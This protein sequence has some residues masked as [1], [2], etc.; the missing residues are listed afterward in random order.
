MDNQTVL[1]YYMNSADPFRTGLTLNQ[2]TG[3]SYLLQPVAYRESLDLADGNSLVESLLGVKN[4][5]SCAAGKGVYS[6]DCS[7]LVFNLWHRSGE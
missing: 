7:N 4:I 6:Q 5:H 1:I 3:R 2:P